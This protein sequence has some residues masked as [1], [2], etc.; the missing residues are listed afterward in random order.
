V[1]RYLARIRPGPTKPGSQTWAT[2]L[3]NHARDIVAVDTFVVPTIRFR[4]LYIFII[5]GLERRRLIFANVTTNPTAE[6]LA[7]QGR[8]RLPLGHGTEVPYPRPR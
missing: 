7:Q 4:V 8:E 5:L 1:S 2:F 3:K 6:W